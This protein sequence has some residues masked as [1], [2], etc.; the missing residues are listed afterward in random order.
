MTSTWNFS[1]Y[2]A[3]N[4]ITNPIKH[5]ID[6]HAVCDAVAKSRLNVLSKVVSIWISLAICGHQ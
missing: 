2:V 4:T 1:K 5:V 3:K 6:A